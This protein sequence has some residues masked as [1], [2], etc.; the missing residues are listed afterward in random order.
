MSKEIREHIDKFNKFRLSE[1]LNISDVSSSQNQH[2][3]IVHHEGRD[4]IH[5]TVI[6]YSL[7]P[8]IDKMIN[9]GLNTQQQVENMLNIIYNNT[10]EHLMC[11]TYVLEDY[12]KIGK[13]NIV[14]C[15]HL[16]EL[17]S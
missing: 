8:Q 11:Q 1:N 15:I 10:L 14:K 5:F 2:L 13:Y 16:S 6:D 12:T 17:G 3:L 7:Y 9:D 4:E